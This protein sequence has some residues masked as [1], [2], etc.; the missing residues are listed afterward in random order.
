MYYLSDKASGSVVLAEA[1]R[2]SAVPRVEECK[3]EDDGKYPIY[4]RQRE[5]KGD[6]GKEPFPCSALESIGAV[7]EKSV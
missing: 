3:G 2:D 1:P 5:Y 4:G 7:G 6:E